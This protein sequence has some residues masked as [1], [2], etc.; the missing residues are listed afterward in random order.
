M[1]TVDKECISCEE[2]QPFNECPKSKR[3]CGHHCNHVWSHD[4]CCWCGKEFNEEEE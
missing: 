3:N 2:E 4:S 1:N